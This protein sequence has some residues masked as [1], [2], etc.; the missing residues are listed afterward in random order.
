MY[1]S[2]L[3]LRWTELPTCTCISGPPDIVAFATGKKKTESDKLKISPLCVFDHR[4]KLTYG[5]LG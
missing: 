1:F 2:I 5:E 4:T 3:H